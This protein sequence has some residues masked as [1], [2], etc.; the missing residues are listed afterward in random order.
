MSNGANGDGIK[1][2]VVKGF[3]E[4]LKGP[5]FANFMLAGL[6]GMIG[7]AVIVGFPWLFDRLDA[8][9]KVQSERHEATVIKIEASH[10][11]TEE[12]QLNAFITEQRETRAA[13][14]EEREAA[15]EW[16]RAIQD[17]LRR[18]LKTGAVEIDNGAPIANVPGVHKE[19]T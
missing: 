6:V 7:Y 4:G 1:S 3:L 16:N 5:A 10:S 9:A 19:G 2:Q 14:K 18:F 11:E 13:A 17:E 15:R 8:S 12:K